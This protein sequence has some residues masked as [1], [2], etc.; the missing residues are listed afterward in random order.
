ML[1]FVWS[2]LHFIQNIKLSKLLLSTTVPKNLV[3]YNPSIHYILY[4]SSFKYERFFG[5]KQLT[6]Y[7]KRNVR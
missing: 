3:W 6:Q 5:I 4:I 7:V 2:T 1:I